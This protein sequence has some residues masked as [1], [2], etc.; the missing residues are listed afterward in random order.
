MLL[1][2]NSF[3]GL[4]CTPEEKPHSYIGFMARAEGIGAKELFQEI[5]KIALERIN[6]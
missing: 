2:A 6:N 4:M 3:A 1:E 5:I